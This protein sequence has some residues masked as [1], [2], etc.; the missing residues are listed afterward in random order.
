MNASQRLKQREQLAFVPRIDVTDEGRRCFAH[1]SLKAI[2]NE[3]ARSYWWP[4][5]VYKLRGGTPIDQVGAIS[6]AAAGNRWL[7]IR[8]SFRVI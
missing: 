1:F 7:A 2:L 6:D 4:M 8:A 5:T 3:L